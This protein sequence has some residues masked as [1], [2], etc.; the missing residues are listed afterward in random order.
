MA[1]SLSQPNSADSSL[2]TRQPTIG[3]CHF[4]PAEVS[5]YIAS[6]SS[7]RLRREPPQE[8]AFLGSLPRRQS[9]R[10]A[11]RATSACVASRLSPPAKSA[12]LGCFCM[13]RHNLSYIF[14][15]KFIIKGLTP[16]SCGVIICIQATLWVV[17]SWQSSR[18]VV[19]QS[20]RGQVCR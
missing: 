14:N 6:N 13:G 9:F 8:G 12:V 11:A 4:V 7:T 2:C 10:P 1:Q 17:H 18:K 19:T 3:A 15:K 16:L 20:Y 5:F